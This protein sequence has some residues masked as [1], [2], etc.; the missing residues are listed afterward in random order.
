[1]PASASSA[2]TAPTDQPATSSLPARLADAVTTATT[3]GN[4]AAAPPAIGAELPLL[5]EALAARP[6]PRRARGVR[7]QLLVVLLL[8]CCA[9]LAQHSS[10]VAIAEW[11]SHSGPAVL[12][13]LGWND[14]STRRR[15]PC[16]STIRRLL[17]CQTPGS[18]ETSMTASGHAPSGEVTRLPPGVV[19]GR[20]AQ[21]RR[22]GGSARRRRA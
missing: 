13:A 6:D 7:H 22:R 18:M 14:V 19:V 4:R 3:S 16:E 21:R 2:A 20:H 10:Y 11:V 5:L 12:D 15:L 8:E 17:N 1:M 9:V